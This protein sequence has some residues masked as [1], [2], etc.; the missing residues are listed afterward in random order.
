MF[1]LLSNNLL[2]QA[3]YVFDADTTA[4]PVMKA[5]FFAFD[6]TGKQITNLSPSDFKITENGVAR[7]VLSVN[8]PPVQPP[9]ALSSVLVMDASGSMEDSNIL[10]AKTGAMAWFNALPSELSECAVTAFDTNN[11]YVRDFTKDRDKLRKDIMFINALGGTD[12]NAAFI[13]PVAGGILVAKTG[14][15]KKVVI[16]LSDGQ[17]NFEPNTQEIISRAKQSD[18]SIYAIILGFECPDCL[19][20]ITS[21]TGGQWFENITTEEQ[22]RQV[23]L[24]ILQVTQGNEPCIV[25]WES[26]IACQ[27]GLF[28]VNITL[29]SSGAADDLSYRYPNGKEANLEFDPNPVKILKAV[30]DTCV[31]VKVTARNIDFHVTNVTTTNPAFRVEPTVNFSL[32]AGESRDLTLCYTPL[33]SGYTYCNFTFESN[34]CPVGL[35]AIGGFP[36]KKP[37]KKTIKL[38]HPNGGEV[39]LAG[40]DTVI[41]WEGVLPNE[42][43]TF[44]YSTDSGANWIMVAE[45]LTGL[46]YKWR[47]PNTPGNHYLARVTAQSVFV[48]YHEVQICDQVWMDHNLEVEFYRNGDPIRHTKTWEEWNY[49]YNEKIGAWCYYD[50]NPAN[51]EIYGKLYNRWAVID[52]RGLAPD[53]WHIST[54]AEWDAML[55]CLGGWSIAGG[56]LKSTG[57]VENGDGLWYNPN[58]GATNES[59]FSALPGGM[60]HNSCVNIGRAGYWWF[61]ENGTVSMYENCMGLYNDSFSVLNTSFGGIFNHGLSVR[62]V[63]D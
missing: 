63:K 58:T 23:Y 5:K 49:A 21:Q 33:D 7:K 32:K 57:T 36:G 54:K 59:G 51:G 14:K 3:L 62:C 52:P 22:A 8:C 2:P 40:S 55:N 19:K 42:P 15:Y 31:T 45:N 44:E 28:D 25:E 16:L 29:L 60:Y 24:S 1:V 46:S 18:V 39:F 35:D 20:E 41:A 47:V 17:P 10:M 48:E 38:L 30:K 6:S 13:K 43:V 34:P 37:S 11:Y 56:K 61:Y 9:L 50:L 26:E 4:F 27:G 12:Y 53:G